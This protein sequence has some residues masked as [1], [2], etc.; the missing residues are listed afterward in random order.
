MMR[1]ELQR[2]QLIR[3]LA[4]DKEFEVLEVGVFAS[5]GRP[6]D[7]LRAVEV[8]YGA[9]GIKNTDDVKIGDTIALASEP[10][11]LSLLRLLGGVS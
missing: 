6:A 4:T 5:K 11:R 1:G 7:C 8:G 2:R 3:L 9:A 10:F